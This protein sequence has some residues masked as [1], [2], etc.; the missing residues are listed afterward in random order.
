VL[1]LDRRVFGIRREGGGQVVLALVNLSDQPVTV[2]P[3]A[4]QG[5]QMIDLFSSHRIPAG[6]Q[7]ALAPYQYAWLQVCR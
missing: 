6:R 4:G 1:E 2:S 5:E 3:S 7:M